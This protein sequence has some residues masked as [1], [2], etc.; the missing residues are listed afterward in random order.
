MSNAFFILLVSLLFSFNAK[1]NA[2]DFDWSTLDRRGDYKAPDNFP[3]SEK[4]TLAQQGYFD[5]GCGLP[6]KDLGNLAKLSN[7]EKTYCYNSDGRLEYFTIHNNRIY[8]AAAKQPGDMD[9]TTPEVAFDM[10]Q[11]PLGYFG[12]LGNEGLRVRVARNQFGDLEVF[13]P[14][15]DGRICHFKQDKGPDKTWKYFLTGKSGKNDGW[16]FPTC[17]LGYSREPIYPSPQTRE[18]FPD[19]TSVCEPAF[20]YHCELDPQLIDFV[21]SKNQLGLTEINALYK[22]NYK[23]GPFDEVR[24][25]DGSDYLRIINYHKNPGNNKWFYIVHQPT[26]DLNDIKYAFD[27]VHLF[28]TEPRLIPKR[29]AD[30]NFALGLKF[31]GRDGGDNYYSWNRWLIQAFDPGSRQS[32]Y[33]ARWYW[34]SYDQP[35]SKSNRPE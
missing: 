19:P 21:V 30:G 22:F 2:S 27:Q 12:V 26:W 29:T 8:H 15:A 11:A 3:E 18:L 13:Y 9:A 7:N 10:S 20:A 23:V 25:V 24:G 17:E 32:N 6:G 5:T 34:F 14:A 4:Q 33:R 28:L 16:T 35:K 1:L 31:N